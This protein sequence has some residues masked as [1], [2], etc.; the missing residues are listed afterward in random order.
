MPRVGQG[1]VLSVLCILLSWATAGWAQTIR[2]PPRVFQSELLADRVAQ[3]LTVESNLLGGYDDNLAPPGSG[4]Q[5]FE[6]RPSGYTGVA[7]ARVHYAVGLQER[8]LELTGGGFVNAF[9]N[10]GVKPG[11]GADLEIRARTDIG[12]NSE[13]SAAQNVRSNPFFGLAA[14][15]SLQPTSPG[16]PGL[17]T[18][19]LN[20]FT[21]SRSLALNT[22]AA[23]SHRW[24]PRTTTDFSYGFSETT[25][26]DEIAFD[27]RRHTANMSYD[28]AM[29]RSS[30]FEASYRYA[31]FESIDISGGGV[32][33]KDHTFHAGFRYGKEL[34]PTRGVR[35]AGGA[36]PI[37]TETVS[38]VTGLPRQ[39]WSPSG[40]GRASIDLGRTWTVSADYRRSTTVLQ[41]LTP[42]PFLTDAGSVRLGGL[43]TGRLEASVAGIYSNGNT[44]G[45]LDSLEPGRF[46]SYAL[47]GQLRVLVTPWW[48]ALLS[49]THYRYTLN[50]VASESLGVP[51]RL[52]RNAALVGV[53]L[54]LPLIGS[55]D[56]LPQNWDRGSR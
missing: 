39:F 43:L 42:Q 20:V 13:L 6:A 7:S 33:I 40:Y 4:G 35:V 8:R 38:S 54:Q 30:G 16:A 11:Y 52:N 45:A 41:G 10:I 3:A 24:T 48:S 5:P 9:S 49:Y 34:S 44:G 36:G 27:G 26:E 50:S 2:P 18:S 12:R 22:R 37:V 15:E 25:Y 46:D 19:P 56:G 23:F 31:G 29:G 47:T 28:R 55:F 21:E 1:S 51:P 32:P 14:F 53:T 17:D